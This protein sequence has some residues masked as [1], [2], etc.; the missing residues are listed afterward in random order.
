EESAND[1]AD[2]LVGG[3]DMDILFGMGGNDILIGGGT[4]V[5]GVGGS[6]DDLALKLNVAIT[7]LDNAQATEAI[8][9]AIGSKAESD[10][11]ALNALIDSLETGSDSADLLFGGSGADVLIGS[12][13]NDYLS[14]GEGKDVLFGGSGSDIFVYD[15]DDI[16]V[17]GGS[18]LD[19]L[20]GSDDT[21][22]LDTLLSGGMENAPMINGVEVLVRG[23]VDTGLTSLDKLS[24]ELG[25]TV[26]DSRITLGKGW[27]QGE[28][29]TVGEGADAITVNTY[30]HGSGD[31]MITLETSIAANQILLNN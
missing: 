29:T 21:P 14:G 2:F 13:G 22:S 4:N 19:I 12:E 15:A 7:G 9:N 17:S 26:G 30:T 23:A 27:T 18:G 11:D 25:I 10:V 24:S 16:L 1:K 6:I 3:D 28:S 20:L 5:S 8:V 31:D